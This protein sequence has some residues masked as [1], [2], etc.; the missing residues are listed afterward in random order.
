MIWT[1][2]LMGSDLPGGVVCGPG[3]I[4]PHGGRLLSV[5]SRS[6]LGSNV[7]L[8]QH[9]ILGTTLGDARAP[10][11]GDDVFVGPRATILGGV[12]VGS[13]TIIGAHAVVT[14]SVPDDSIAFGI[15]AHAKPRT[16]DVWVFA[17][18]D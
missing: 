7:T 16:S 15:P 18:T 17:K 9:V 6:V 10:K 1:K 3:V 11:I 12:E 14:K 4:L 13:R 5:N 8:Q 2:M